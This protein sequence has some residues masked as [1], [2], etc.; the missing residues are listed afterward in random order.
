MISNQCVKHQH[1]HQP[2]RTTFK[3]KSKKTKQ[4]VAYSNDELTELNN[5]IQH[6]KHQAID[7]KK[8]L[9]QSISNTD[10][11]IDTIALQ[12][13]VIHNH[14]AVIAEMKAG[15]D[16]DKEFFKQTVEK[17]ET[18][19]TK[20]MTENKELMEKLKQIESALDSPSPR[21]RCKEI[22]LKPPR[23]KVAKKNPKPKKHVSANPSGIPKPSR[24]K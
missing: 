17:Y 14:E 16:A 20:L 21:E 5:E 6:W 7:F 15:Y 12:N 23:S 22:E 13:N 4:P 11:Q 18:M 8:K 9:R 2:E 3:R 19:N 10:A 24:W 1:R